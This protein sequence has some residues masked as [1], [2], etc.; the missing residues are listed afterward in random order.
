MVK[1]DDM[2]RRP[3][4]ILSSIGVTAVIFACSLT[5]VFQTPPLLV[6]VLLCAYMVAFSSGMGPLTWLLASEVLPLRQRAKG[7]TLCSF[8]NRLISG[9]VALSTLTTCNALGQAGFFA[10]YGCI[11]ILGTLFY[12]LYVPETKGKTLEEITELFAAI[13]GENGDQA[14]RVVDVLPGH[15]VPHT[16][17]TPLRANLSVDAMNF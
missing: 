5:F 7:M 4:L 13:S 11:S 14:I 3:L 1:V 10:F 15:A 12:I 2:G 6:V 17:L 16:E 8:I 9:V